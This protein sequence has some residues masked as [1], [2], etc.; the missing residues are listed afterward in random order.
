MFKLLIGVVVWLAFNVAG[1]ICSWPF[2][3][4]VLLTLCFL[5][6][7]VIWA[8]D[9]AGQKVQDLFKEVP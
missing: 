3:A 7:L 5:L 8:F 1:F 4:G 9:G 6:F 2:G